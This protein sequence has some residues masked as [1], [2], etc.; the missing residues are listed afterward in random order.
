MF[1]YYL[2]VELIME[3]GVLFNIMEHLQ[4]LHIPEIITAALQ[5]SPQNLYGT[6]LII[7]GA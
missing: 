2:P 1:L 5:K 6:M 4:A 7:G 3:M